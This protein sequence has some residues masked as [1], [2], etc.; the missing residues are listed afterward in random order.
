MKQYSIKTYL[1][2]LALLS[3][4][5]M[6]AAAET[7]EHQC[8]ID[9]VKQAQSVVMYHTRGIVSEDMADA[10]MSAVRRKVR[11]EVFVGRPD[12]TYAN[13]KSFMDGFFLTWNATASDS[14]TTLLGMGACILG[15]TQADAFLVTDPFQWKS[16]DHPALVDSGELTRDL[17]KV[18]EY[19]NIVDTEEFVQCKLDN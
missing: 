10:L 19:A 8:Q 7:C 4:S 15:N 17:A 18:A 5:A 9:L 2:G 1:A 11:V 13:L 14:D 16:A 12:E 3:A 6:P